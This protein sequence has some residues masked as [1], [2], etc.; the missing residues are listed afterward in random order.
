[1]QKDELRRPGIEPLRSISNM[2]EASDEKIITG[3]HRN[4][5]CTAVATMDL[6]IPLERESRDELIQRTLPLTEGC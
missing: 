5:A 3:A 4:G 2:S 1:M 6:W